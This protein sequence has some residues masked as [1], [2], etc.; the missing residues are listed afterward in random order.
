M[1]LRQLHA[2]LAEHDRSVFATGPL[3]LDY[4]LEYAARGIPVFPLKPRGKKPFQGSH[5]FKDAS[6]DP[7]TIREWWDVARTPDANIGAPTGVCFDVLD[8]DPDGLDTL[9]ELVGGDDAL[10]C[11]PVTRTPRGGAHFWYEPTGLGNRAG[12]VRGI[13]WRGDG[14]YAVLPPS[15]GANGIEYA[16]HVKDGE[17][18]DLERALVPVPVWLCA[19]LEAPNVAN[20]DR[21]NRR[22]VDVRERAGT[23]RRGFWHK[24]T[25]P[26]SANYAAV[27]VEAEARAVA[28]AAVGTRNDQLNRSTHTL[29]RL[30]D[31]D[32]TT[33]ETVMLAA[34]LDAGLP[35]HE[36]LRTIGSAL[37]ARGLA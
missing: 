27:A 16:W 7:D 24:F 2:A 13:D 5:G 19:L 9:S 31:L 21:Q 35:E 6:T 20:A 30:D 22:V 11:G 37:K 1:S 34:A 17:T 15:L 36:A 32:A 4:A 23:T 12:F 8:V 25:A 26:K 10:A 3:M 14:G 28:G 33:I 29:A 18:F